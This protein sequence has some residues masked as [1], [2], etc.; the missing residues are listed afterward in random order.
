MG[1]RSFWGIR[2]PVAGVIGSS[3]GGYKRKMRFMTALILALP[4]IAQPKTERDQPG[5]WK[6]HVMTPKGGWFDTPSPHPLAHF[7]QYPALLDES[8]DFCYLCSRQK[9]L[10]EARA[11]REPGAE[12]RRVGTIQGLTI[13]DV[14]Y[15]FQS[16]GAVD[17][18]SILVRTAPNVYRE[19]YHC[20]PIGVDAT[21]LPSIIVRVGTELLL[22]SRYI[23]GGNKGI[24]VDD[25][26]WFGQTGAS[27]VD[28]APVW[29]AG[30]AVLPQGQGLRLWG[31][32]DA[33]SPETLPSMK[34][35]L[36][37]WNYNSSLCCEP[38]IVEVAFKLDRGHV[39]V[40]EAHY[41]PN[42]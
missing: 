17:W 8:G 18:K 1:L 41:N 5:P 13:Y 10:A 9:K 38:G 25:Y 6:R 12:V 14:F 32:G 19:I 26:Y 16:E 24:Y 39:I 7:T 28:F 35:K 31:G 37:V 22:N 36:L 40:T 3:G 30:L 11:A 34:F 27:L 42:P 2:W 20:E 15:H 23:A 21:A 4:L 33:N 29:D